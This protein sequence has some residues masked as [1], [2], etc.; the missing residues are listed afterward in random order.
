MINPPMEKIDARKLPREAQEEMRR[1][2]MRLREELNLTWKEIARVVGVSISTVFAWSNRYMMKGLQGLKSQK[3]GRRH[4]S[5]EGRGR[6]PGVKQAPRHPSAPPLSRPCGP[7]SPASGRGVCSFF[8]F[9]L[10]ETR[11]SDILVRHRAVENALSLGEAPMSDK[12][13]RPTLIPLA[14]S[15]CRR[16]GLPARQAAPGRAPVRIQA[17]DV[18]QVCPTNPPEPLSHLRERVARR[19]GRGNG[20]MSDR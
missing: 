11:R 3:R 5:G 20:V 15:G 8:S 4:L 13:V 17:P 1:Q 14:P 12:Y 2:A 7:P 9:P 16:S 19:V 10:V 6:G 18:G